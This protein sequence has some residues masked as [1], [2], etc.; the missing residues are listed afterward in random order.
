MY[1]VEVVNFH[2]LGLIFL[3]PLEDMA[4][5]ILMAIN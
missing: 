5:V 1:I 3:F 2:A 4:A